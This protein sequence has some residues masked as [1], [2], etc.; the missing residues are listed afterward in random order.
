MVSSKDMHNVIDGISPYRKEVRQEN[1]IHEKKK[2]SDESARV[3]DFRRLKQVTKSDMQ[4]V[5]VNP[6]EN[7]LFKKLITRKD[8]QN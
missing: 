6:R 1:K 4:K 2:G 8:D 5:P 7:Q 3:I